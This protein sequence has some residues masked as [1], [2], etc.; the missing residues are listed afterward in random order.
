M[1]ARPLPRVPAERRGKAKRQRV[2]G[3]R[4][5]RF[6]TQRRRRRTRRLR[7]QDAARIVGIV[8]A[9]TVVGMLYLSLL[10][11]VDSLHHQIRIEAKHIADLQYENQKLAERVEALRS[12]DRLAQVAARLGMHDASAYAV[13]R[14]PVVAAGQPA[15]RHDAFALL[16]ALSSAFA[17]R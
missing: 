14:A 13:V 16:G 15:E 17:P 1:I 6:A 11:N 12:D 7:Y 9:L 2:A 4:A 5:G 8:T 3:T 10:T